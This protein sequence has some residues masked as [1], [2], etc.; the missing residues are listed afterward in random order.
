MCL[1]TIDFALENESG[2]LVG[3]GYKVVYVEED[4]T[5]GG[6]DFLSGLTD[7]RWLQAEAPV[8]HTDDDCK[9]YL[10]GFHIFLTAEEARRYV[11]SDKDFL[12]IKVKFKKVLAFG[13]QSN[14]DEN[15]KPLLSPCVIANEIKFVQE[16]EGI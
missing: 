16:M 9:Q 1:S 15:D 3:Y 11:G 4:G 5:Y 7:N 14:Y 6:T 10:A 13:R 8:I 12:V 2:E